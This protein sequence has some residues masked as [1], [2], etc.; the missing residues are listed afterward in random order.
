M[1]GVRAE[2]F[3]EYDQSVRVLPDRESDYE[4]SLDLE[5]PDERARGAD[6]ELLA[7]RFTWFAA[8]RV[9]TRKRYRGDARRI[10]FPSDARQRALA[11]KQRMLDPTI[12]HATLPITRHLSL[13]CCWLLTHCF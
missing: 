8:Q 11:Q 4:F 2:G 10:E 3:K 7:G 9:S 12:V 6:S 5:D 1:V 13:L